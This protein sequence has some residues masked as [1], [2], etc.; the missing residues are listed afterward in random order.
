MSESLGIDN[1]PKKVERVYN[2]LPDKVARLR[3]GVEKSPSIPSNI[4]L[5]KKL[6][7]LEFIRSRLFQSIEEHK[8]EY[9]KKFGGDTI[10]RVE[11]ELKEL[12]MR[13][14][15]IDSQ[16]AG[17]AATKRVEELHEMGYDT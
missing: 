9:V 8:P 14:Q 15:E 17:E 5:G 16:R 2:N 13:I 7:R 3:K 11:Q 4:T 1:P 12:S 10:E 6:S